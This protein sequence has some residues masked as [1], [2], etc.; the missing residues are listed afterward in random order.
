M[1][2]FNFQMQ[3]RTL[4]FQIVLNVRGVW[5]SSIILWDDII[6]SCSGNRC[7]PNWIMVISQADDSDK[8]DAFLNASVNAPFEPDRPQ[9][10]SPIVTEKKHAAGINMILRSIGANKLVREKSAENLDLHYLKTNS[11]NNIAADTSWNLVDISS[12]I[13]I[14]GWNR[15]SY[16]ISTLP[17]K[18]TMQMHQNTKLPFNRN[19][20]NLTHSVLRVLLRYLNF[21]L[22]SRLDSWS[23]HSYTYSHITI[24][25][26]RKLSI[27]WEDSGAR[28]QNKTFLNASCDRFQW[29]RYK[30]AP[31]KSALYIEQ[32]T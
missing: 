4:T 10:D 11:D 22:S 21:K 28:T 31:V 9:A 19:R 20:F 24:A 13:C 27:W 12:K 29:H 17:L 16:D 5:G 30:I 3:Y 32:N 14:I 8:D 7:R 15:V 18:H 25:V 1:H 2:L 26:F 23:N 6:L